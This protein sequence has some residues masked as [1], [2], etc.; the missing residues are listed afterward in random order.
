LG[1]S[2]FGHAGAGHLR[3]SYASSIEIIEIA[4]ERMRAAIPKY[5]D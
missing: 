4:L 5:R 2:S 3:L 1:G